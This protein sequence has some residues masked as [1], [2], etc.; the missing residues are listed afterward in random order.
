MSFIWQL[1]MLAVTGFIAGLGF[2]YA[3]KFVRGRGAA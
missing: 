3:S 1:V 2:W